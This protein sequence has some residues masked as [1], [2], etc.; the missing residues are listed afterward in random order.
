MLIAV[1]KT[2]D[3]SPDGVTVRRYAAG[4]IHQMPEALAAV[5]I[6]NQWGEAVSE[7]KSA[8]GPKENK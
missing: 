1:T 7:K 4:E 3:A 2:M 5:F 8:K 6:Q